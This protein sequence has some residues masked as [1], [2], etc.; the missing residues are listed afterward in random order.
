MLML[1]KKN[2]RKYFRI[3]ER[4]LFTKIK[5]FFRVIYRYF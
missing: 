3:S 1:L 4:K 2:G 5:I